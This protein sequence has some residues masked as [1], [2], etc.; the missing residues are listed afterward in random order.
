MVLRRAGTGR[1]RRHPAAQVAPPTRLPIAGKKNDKEAQLGAYLR[2]ASA[3]EADARRCYAEGFDD[4][5]DF[6][7][8]LV[9]DGCF[10]LE[11]FLRKGEGQLAAPGGAKWAWQH[12]YHD[13]LLLENQ[14]PFFVLEKLYGE[15]GGPNPR[16]QATAP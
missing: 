2:A 16:S 8:M 1:A 9:L 15:D 13:V 12:M 10:L 6:A 7:E 3:L 11:F 4:A 14:I 5:G